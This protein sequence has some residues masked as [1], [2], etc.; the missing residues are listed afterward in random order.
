MCVACRR[1]SVKRLL[2]RVVRGADGVATVDRA[3]RATGRGTYLHP[4]AG[5]VE[6]ARKRRSL[7]RSLAA[8]VPPELWA[9]LTA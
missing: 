6:M 1:K 2:V 8:S 7:E 5:C 9:E 3:G 4:E